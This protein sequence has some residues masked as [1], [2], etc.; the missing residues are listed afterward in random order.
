[1]AYYLM[2]VPASDYGWNEWAK[3]AGAIVLAGCLAVLALV[4][5]VTL[6]PV[7][8]GM[9]LVQSWHRL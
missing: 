9:A 2:D 5:F 4:A 1:M 7:L 8:L 3:I 6:L